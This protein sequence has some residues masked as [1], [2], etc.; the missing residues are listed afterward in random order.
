MRN[1]IL[2][3]L[4]CLNLYIFGIDN[5]S[6]FN[7]IKEYKQIHSNW[8]PIKINE[9]EYMTDYMNLVFML[10]TDY[11]LSISDNCVDSLV[12]ICRNRHIPLYSSL[13]PEEYGL[14]V[15]EKPDSIYSVE[16]ILNKYVDRDGY[17]LPWQFDNSFR[18]GDVLYSLYVNH[19]AVQTD[20]MT[21][22]KYI[23]Y[24]ETANKGFVKINP[25]GNLSVRGVSK[26][27][28]S[29]AFEYI[30]ITING[31]V[32]MSRQK[33]INDFFFRGIQMLDTRLL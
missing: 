24:V 15:V 13:L 31:R 14:L 11:G 9:R 26:H 19:I 7:N 27:K 2:L 25:S 33:N 18:E 32:Y 8:F 4:L 28:H 17:I 3:V 12:E 10:C 20:C 21:G 6:I 16:D 30:P 1:L 22:Y 5:R 29:E 23:P